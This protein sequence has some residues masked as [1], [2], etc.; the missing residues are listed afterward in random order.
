MTDRTQIAPSPLAGTVRPQGRAVPTG[1]P[2]ASLWTR[3]K[4]A[5]AMYA[6]ILPGFVFFVVF[7]YVPLL[8]NVVAF[9]DFSPFLGIFG[10][11]WV[12][13]Q[14]FIDIFSDPEVLNAVKNT[15]IISL[16]QIVFSF[17][18]PILLAL[19]L[20][21]LVSDRLK[22]FLQGVVYLPHFISWVIVISIWQQVL[23]GAG[24]VAGL[25][26]KIGLHDVNIM[27]NPDTFAVL[28]TSQVIWKDV[29]WGTI[30]FFAAILAIPQELYESAATDGASAWR[31]TWHITLPGLVPIISLLLIL[32]IGNV[33]TVGFEQILLQQ[34]AVGSDASEVID[35][36]VYFRGIAGGDWGLAAAASLFKGVIGTLLVVGANK[37][38]KRMGTGGIF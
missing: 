19:L 22:R 8:G 24:P 32:Q 1:R 27:T 37:L 15:L 26:D 11:P 12:G 10:S 16:L 20:N 14:N 7:A 3:M 36:F 31:R 9:Q 18:A 25:L 6:F 29:G 4:R 17:P 5:R 13:L 34:P 38:A 33:L 30:I 21:S 23:G 2:R 35:T 28:V